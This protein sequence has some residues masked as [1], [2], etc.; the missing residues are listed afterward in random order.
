MKKDVEALETF[1]SQS[2]SSIIATYMMGKAKQCICLYQVFIFYEP[3][4]ASGNEFSFS[5]EVSVESTEV[6]LLEQPKCCRSDF[7][8]LISLQYQF[9]PLQV[10]LEKY[11]CWAKVESVAKDVQKNPRICLK[12]LLQNKVCVLIFIFI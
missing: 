7:L 4:C 8:F 5:T 9:Y 6:Y 10:A 11:N 1:L 2:P 12:S 3:F